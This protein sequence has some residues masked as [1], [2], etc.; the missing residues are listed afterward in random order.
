MA[1]SSTPAAVHDAHDA[2]LLAALASGDDLSSSER[3][4]ADALVRDC[5]ECSSLVADIRLIT[6][7][8]AALPAPV[9]RRD[10]RLTD[11][12]AAGL[13]LT[14]WR[15]LIAAFGSARFAFAT[16]LAA[17][18]VAVGLVVALVTVVPGTAGPFASTSMSRDASAPVAGAGAA[19][20][21]GGA[22]ATIAAPAIAPMPVAS[23]AA[24]L[25]LPVPVPSTARDLATS[26]AAGSEL[27]G[28]AAM[29]APGPPTSA[30][31]GPATVAGAPGEQA[32]S[33]AAAVEVAPAPAQ[34]TGGVAAIPAA[35]TSPDAG[36]GST[37]MGWLAT[38][39]M[40]LVTAGLLLLGLRLVGA[41]VLSR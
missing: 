11:A 14:G 18:L 41:R 34:A 28:N 1:V 25:A 8:T 13:R 35:A 29:I 12:D 30:T 26:P 9:R 10:F 38:A 5:P 4:R 37:S 36:A 2:L 20:V 21:T 17:G 40:L 23:T 22:E 24:G 31:S 7:A 6:S 39:S 27:P 16:P 3:A 32:S 19:A 33:A 15:R